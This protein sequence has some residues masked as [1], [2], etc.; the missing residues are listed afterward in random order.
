MISDSVGLFRCNTLAAAIVV[1]AFLA[2]G[3]KSGDHAAADSTAAA[4]KPPGALAT[5]APPPCTDGV[6]AYPLPNNAPPALKDLRDARAAA[7]LADDG[8]SGRLPL[9]AQGFLA[10]RGRTRVN[11]C[12]RKFALDK[13][14]YGQGIVIGAIR[15]KHKSPAEALYLAADQVPKDDDELRAAIIVFYRT[16]GYPQEVAGTDPL[17][18]DSLYGNWVMFQILESDA[19]RYVKPVRS[20]KLRK[21]GHD[22][23]KQD[24][25]AAHSTFI[26]CSKLNK[27]MAVDDSLGVKFDSTLKLVQAVSTAAADNRI[28]FQDQLR[29]ERCHLDGKT[30]CDH[31]TST[32]KVELK[33][34]QF[35]DLG[36]LTNEQRASFFRLVK[37][38][39]FDST[40]D[41]YWLSCGVGCCTAG[42]F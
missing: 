35:A 30:D 40:S 14:A 25:S 13:L 1:A 28:P 5:L 19:G 6:L 2:M 24:Y 26:A 41:P 15:F 38:S 27:L 18:P 36:A 12:A 20:G 10:Q 42:D 7:N 17:H 33:E 3:C 9:D 16:N 4:T 22:T 29:R 21:C 8:E 32:L 39:N 34:G 23:P 11:G 37:A 31:G